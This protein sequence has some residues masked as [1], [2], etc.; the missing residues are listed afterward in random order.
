MNLI[1]EIR[2][3]PISSINRTGRTRADFG[4]IPKFWEELKD[5][6]LHPPVV[7]D[8]GNGSYKLIGGERRILAHIHGGQTEVL[9][10]VT[11]HDLDE[12][13]IKSLEI[14][15]NVGR[16]DFNYAEEVKYKAE[17][18]ALMQKKFGVKGSGPSSG[19]S[20]HDTASMLNENVGLTSQDLKLAKAIELVP[21]LGQMKNRSEAMKFVNQVIAQV[22]NQRIAA[23]I[24]K[25]EV[26]TSSNERKKKLSDSYIIGDFLEKVKTIPNEH[27]DFIECDPPYGID[28]NKNKELQTLNLEMEEYSEV[29]IPAYQEFIKQ[30]CRES[31]RVLKQ[32]SWF[33]LWYGP[34]PNAEIVYQAI[35]KAGFTCSRMNSIWFKE[36]SGAQT[37]NPRFNLGNQYETFYYA[38]KGNAEIQKRGA[39]NVFVHQP[40]APQNKIH[41]TEK[42]IEL[43][44]SIL[45]TFAKPGANILVPFLGSGVTL[46]AAA[47]VYMT[48][49]GYDLSQ[50]FKDSHT[51]AVYAE[52]E[53]CVRCGKNSIGK[54][55]YLN[56]ERICEECGEKEEQD[57]TEEME[58]SQ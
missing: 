22:D 58:T 6:M 28:I 44:L 57:I 7:K 48:G 45:Q 31:F 13:D 42:P 47:K 27:F 25:K 23:E 51:L 56:S 9:C 37:M 11:D 36:H 46:R 5:R 21:E 26:N 39:S 10:N 20:L 17:L 18:H 4:D 35:I 30:V 49:I 40:L 38:R 2:T 54:S 14:I 52:E 3:I 24:Q 15:E 32:N 8:L 41:R 19:H 1:K 50:T 29:P 16:K 33:L 55:A 43:Y 53:L 12:F 34:Q